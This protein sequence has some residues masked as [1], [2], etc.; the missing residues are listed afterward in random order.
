MTTKKYS[1]NP[2]SEVLIVRISPELKDKLQA[3]AYSQDRSMGD[4]ARD[5]IL[6]A[7]EAKEAH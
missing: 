2:K 1:R 5:A 6:K 7:I 3:Y 4:I